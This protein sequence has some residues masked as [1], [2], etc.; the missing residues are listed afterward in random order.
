MAEL[1]DNPKRYRPQQNAYG[2]AYHQKNLAE[3]RAKAS[4]YM[5]KWRAANRAKVAESAEKTAR[6][7]VINGKAA[8]HTKSRALLK[9]NHIKNLE[10]LAIRPKPDFCDICGEG[11]RIVFDHC[12]K[13]GHFR[14]WIC[15]RC[16][17]A[18]GAAGDN[19]RLLRML[20][21][22]LERT[23]DGQGPQPSIPGL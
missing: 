14:G 5:R 4:A 7:R 10:L 6:K 21:A 13:R 23:K 1:H 3:Q 11:G 12:H 16:N 9:A 17:R 2:R 18:L 8:Q 19:I 22:Y 20:V 15:D